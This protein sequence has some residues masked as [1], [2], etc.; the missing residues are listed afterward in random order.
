MRHTTSELEALWRGAMLRA[1]TKLG[2]AER[3]F[4]EPNKDTYVQHSRACICRVLAGMT[5][6]GQ[7][8]SLTRLSN[9]I[10]YKRST[11][12]V[13]HLC[14]WVD[15]RVQ[16]NDEDVIKMLEDIRAAIHGKPVVSQ[17]KTEAA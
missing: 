9:M 16:K 13:K 5:I 17:A 15:C 7:H 2:V 1:L 14:R 4:F 6:D 12:A 10:G 3:E 11:S 8:A